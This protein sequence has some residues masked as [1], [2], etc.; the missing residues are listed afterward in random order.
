MLPSTCLHGPLRTAIIFCLARVPRILHNS[1][2][3]SM[4]AM[5]AF[6]V[7]EGANYLGWR[8][9]PLWLH[10]KTLHVA[11]GRGFRPL[12]RPFLDP[13]QIHVSFG[14]SQGTCRSMPRGRSWPMRR[15]W[16]HRAITACGADSTR[17]AIK[18]A[19]FTRLWPMAACVVS[20]PAFYRSRVR[21]PVRTGP[22]SP[23]SRSITS[24]S[25][26]IAASHSI[27]NG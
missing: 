21:R 10:R 25:R 7:R 11:D 12:L 24:I 3:K 4:P 2:G 15:R 8:Q 16:S 14:R 6:L 19:T 22:T 9:A 20:R 18:M 1:C 27:P 23:R 26:S 13:L 17:P 5:R